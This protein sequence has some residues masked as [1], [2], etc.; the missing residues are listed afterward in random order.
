MTSLKY[1]KLRWGLRKKGADIGSYSTVALAV[2][3]GWRDVRRPPLRSTLA[4]EGRAGM[5]V[6][7]AALRCPMQLLTTQPL[8]AFLGWE[9]GQALMTVPGDAPVPELSQG[10]SY[11]TV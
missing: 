10:G 7:G 8:A 1:S 3:A 11:G 6:H 4:T 5:A 2:C 9:Q